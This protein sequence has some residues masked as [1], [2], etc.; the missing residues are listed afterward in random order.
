MERCWIQMTERKQAPMRSLFRPLECGGKPP[1]SNHVPEPS[2]VPRGQ[3]G[4]RLLDGPAVD[5][6]ELLQLVIRSSTPQGAEAFARRSRRAS[7]GDSAGQH[8]G[9]RRTMIQPAPL[10]RLR[11]RPIDRGGARRRVCPPSRANSP[12]VSPVV[13]RPQ[14]SSPGVSPGVVHHAG[15]ARPKFRQCCPPL[16]ADSPGVFGAVAHDPGMLARSFAQGCPP[17]GASSPGV[18]PGVA[19][20]P[21]QARRESSLCCA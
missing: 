18:S 15:Q 21:R 17:P 14:A 6:D 19:R 9:S 16:R 20:R 7:A 2:H 13:P 11:A 8:G 3:P 5:V 10:S 1:L 12:G 4:G